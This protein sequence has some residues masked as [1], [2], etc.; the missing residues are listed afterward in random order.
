MARFIRINLT[1]PEGYRRES[2]IVDTVNQEIVAAARFDRDA[3]VIAEIL[4]N[5][6][7]EYDAIRERR[8]EV[9]F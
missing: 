9:P 5:H 8:D 7:D 6:A 1:D 4:S 3:V 2:A